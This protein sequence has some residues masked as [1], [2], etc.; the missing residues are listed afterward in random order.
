MITPGKTTNLPEII[1][2]TKACARHMISQGIYQ[3]NEH[4]PNEGAFKK[5]IDRNELFI[6]KQNDK[7]IS[8]IVISTL[9]DEEYKEIN[10]HTPSIDNLYI[11]RLAVHPDFQKQGKARE[12]MDFALTFARNKKTPSIRLDTFSQ[13]KRNHL[14]YEARGYKRLGNVYFPKQSEHPFYCYENVLTYE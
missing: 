14:F 6:Y 13:N 3:W 2:L 7:I 1:A 11:H 10:W 12:M 4:Y 8:T 9:M 5:D